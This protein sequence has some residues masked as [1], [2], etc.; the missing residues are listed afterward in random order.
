MLLFK[1][2]FDVPCDL[3]ET[4]P[5]KLLH[6]V[7]GK[8]QALVAVVV[9]VVLFPDSKIKLQNLLGHNPKV[10]RLRL[11]VCLGV[12]DMRQKEV[13]DDLICAGRLLLF[14]MACTRPLAEVF[15]GLILVH[16]REIDG[17][18]GFGATNEGAP[19]DPREYDG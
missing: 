7:A 15:E 16:L 10:Y 13:V 1:L 12:S 4:D 2:V 19:I 5:E 6:K 18:F 17:P 14:R 9:F 3:V 11:A 8:P